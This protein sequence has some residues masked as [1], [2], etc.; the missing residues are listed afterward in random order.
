MFLAFTFAS[1]V[2]QMQSSNGLRSGDEGGQSSSVIN[3]GQLTCSHRVLILLRVKVQSLVRI[4][5]SFQ[6]TI[7]QHMAINVLPVCPV[8]KIQH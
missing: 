3:L 7:C 8:Y 6:D 1:K 4:P 5:N 2:L